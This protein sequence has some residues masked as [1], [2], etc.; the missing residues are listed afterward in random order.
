MVGWSHEIELWHE[1]EGQKDDSIRKKERI[2]SDYEEDFERE[3]FSF[4][5]S[6][7]LSNTN[8]DL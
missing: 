3:V 4:P 7:A 5:A 8:F 2:K 1:E 6:F